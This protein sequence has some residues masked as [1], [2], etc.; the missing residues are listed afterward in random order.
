MP[1]RSDPRALGHPDA[2]I[3]G[4]LVAGRTFDE[5]CAIGQYHRTWTPAK[6]LEVLDRHL[7]PQLASWRPPEED[8]AWRRVTL[9][10]RQ[11][12]VLDHICLGQSVAEIART[13][14]MSESHTADLVRQ[15]QHALRA[16]SRAECVARVYRDHVEILV[17]PD[18]RRA[19]SET[20]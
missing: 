20:R 5:V 1:N 4:L 13:L 3:L 8:G 18:R 10:S 11:S 15:V 12:E 17:D 9:T 7:R 2:R 19:R 16:H 14:R 6:V